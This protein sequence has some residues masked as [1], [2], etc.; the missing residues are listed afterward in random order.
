M[1]AVGVLLL[2]GR[3]IAGP[4]AAVVLVKIITL[5]TALWAGVLVGWWRG[6]E[7]HLAADAG[8]SLVMLAACILLVGRWLRVL[9]PDNDTFVRS[10]VWE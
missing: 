6:A 4:L 8:P 7:V 2:R 9:I 3:T 10:T 5:F 1:A